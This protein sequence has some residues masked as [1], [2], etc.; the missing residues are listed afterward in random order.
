MSV[1]EKRSIEFNQD[2]R[3]REDV[4]RSCEEATR[5]AQNDLHRARI[6][7]LEPLLGHVSTCKN[8]SCPSSN[9]RKMKQAFLHYSDC[10]RNEEN[11]ANENEANCT[12]CQW[13]FSVLQSH[14][15][16]C[17]RDD[18]P[19]LICQTL[20]TVWRDLKERQEN[21]LRAYCQSCLDV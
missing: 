15:K 18:C 6:R 16:S 11:E 2:I 8:S 13:I 17:M 5:V 7:R 4:L 19:V 20:R 9:C 21:E 12:E 1:Q 14:A 10:I 3:M